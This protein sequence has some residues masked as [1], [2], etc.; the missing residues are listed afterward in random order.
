[1]DIAELDEWLDSTNRRPLLMGVLNVTP[2]SFSDGGRFWAP[3]DAIRRGIDLMRQ[4]ADW[5]DVGGESTR[6]GSEPVDPVEQSCRTVP[7]IE[8]LAKTGAVISIDT[9]SAEVAAA[10]LEAGASII[11][12]I[13]AGTDDPRMPAVMRRARAVALM[14]KRGSPRTMQ[15]DTRYEDVVGEVDKYLLSRAAAVEEAGVE[16]R[17]ILLDPGT[18]FGKNLLQ[19]L[20][21][22]RALP[23]LAAHGRPIL[24]GP[25]RKRFIGAISGEPH[26]DRR[27]FGTAAAVAWAVANQAAVVRVHDVAEMRQVLRVA[28]ALADLP[29][30]VVKES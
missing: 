4:G 5:L 25:S 2:D 1:M 8:A 29:G 30:A 20:L 11:N 14:H 7:V 13:S 3:A 10:A 21:L 17:R 24:V 23:R 15:D 16:R 28:A 22:L 19:N 12:D 18:G 6:P 9:T 26:P 27:Q